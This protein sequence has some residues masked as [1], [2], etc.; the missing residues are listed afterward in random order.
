MVRVLWPSGRVEEWD[1]VLV[2][3]YTTL[4]EGT[5]SDR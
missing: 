4:I 5:G 3:R 1:E 2:D